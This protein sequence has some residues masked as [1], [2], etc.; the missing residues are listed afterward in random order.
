MRD[1]KGKT[2]NI[3]TEE[4][5]SL[6]AL[7]STSTGVLA[8]ALLAVELV[9]GIQSYITSTIIPLMASDLHAQNEYGLVTGA[10]QVAMFLTMPLGRYLLAR[11]PAGRLLTWFTLLTIIGAVV[12]AIAPTIEVFITGRIMVGLAAG[13]LI[14][15]SM[16]VIVSHLDSAWRQLVLAGYAAMWVVTSLVGPFYASWVSA[17]LDWRWAM[18]L[19]LPLLIVAR[20]L[21]IRQLPKTPP[22][23]DRSPLDIPSTLMLAGGIALISVLASVGPWWP[24]LGISGTVLTVI[25]AHRILPKGTFRWRPGRPSAIALLGTLCGIYF[26]AASI[27]TIVAHDTLKFGPVLIG[28]LL[29]TGGLCWAII[30][31]L[32]GKWPATTDQSFKRRVHSGTILLLCGLLTIVF[33]VIAISGL[34]E[35]VM[36]ILGWSFVGSGMGLCY[37][38][39]LSRIVEPPGAP[40]GISAAHAAASTV[41]VEA[42]TTAILSTAATAAASALLIATGITGPV[43]IFMALSIGT[44]PMFI[45]T[46]QVT[47]QPAAQTS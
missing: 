2:R 39:T 4:K 34:M 11:Y 6:G 33:A 15:V 42:I 41:I 18:V 14:T 7:F 16:G 1:R 38:S 5:P 35:T 23:D 9:A 47:K 3:V 30:G 45:L 8:M 31:L 12:S 27:I 28:V 32:C 36:F 29:M 26:G 20:L 40:D 24:I 19:Y 43:T 21:V 22:E 44:V 17:L 46:N 10:G 37:L 13:A 25:A